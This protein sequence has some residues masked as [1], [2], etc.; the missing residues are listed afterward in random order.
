MCRNVV[1]SAVPRDFVF[2]I[3]P[4]PWFGQNRRE[5]MCNNLAAASMGL[6]PGALTVV[7]R[8]RTI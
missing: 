6:E 4:P 1:V 3:L 8:I 2:N 7:K 5:K